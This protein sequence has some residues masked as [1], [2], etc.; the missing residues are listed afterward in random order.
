LG[1]EIEEYLTQRRKGAE[2]Y[3]LEIV[4]VSFSLCASAPLR[5]ACFSS[6]ACEN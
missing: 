5:E 4:I 2:K 1:T 3:G 6:A